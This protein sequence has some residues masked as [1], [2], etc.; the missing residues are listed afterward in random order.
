MRFSQWT[1]EIAMTG[2]LEKSPNCVAKRIVERF[3]GLD[4]FLEEMRREGYT[5][6]P[7]TVYRWT[8][9]RPRGTGGVIPFKWIAPIRRVARLAGVHI[10][11][12]DFVPRE[13]EL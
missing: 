5:I 11:P 13:D 8:Y 10:P 3:G 7:S 9:P 6:H 1:V 4:A 12:E 2:K